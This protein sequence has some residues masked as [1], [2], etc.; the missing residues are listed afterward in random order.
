[1]IYGVVWAAD[2]GENAT[3]NCEDFMDDAVGVSW[4]FCDPVDKSFLTPRPDRSACKSPWVAEV[5]DMVEDNNTSAFKVSQEL[6]SF[7][8]SLYIVT[9]N[10]YCLAS[11]S[12]ASQ[13][14]VH[15]DLICL[16]MNIFI[17]KP[18]C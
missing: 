12:S 2:Y 9:Q 11:S 5:V 16:A 3:H 4:W 14:V 1:M 6:V 17:V 15:I 8:S 18:C 13:T 7:F 10:M